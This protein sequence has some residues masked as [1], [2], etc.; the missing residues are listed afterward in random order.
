MLFFFPTTDFS[1]SKDVHQD[2]PSIFG[3]LQSPATIKCNHSISIYNTILWYQKP[4][5][6]SA[7]KLI[8]YVFYTDVVLEKEIKNRFNVSGDGSKYSNLVI[9]ELQ[10]DD[11]STYYCAASAQ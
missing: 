5:S 9:E 3:S 10:P 11:S 8:G 4:V 1:L 2:P 7:L 6:D